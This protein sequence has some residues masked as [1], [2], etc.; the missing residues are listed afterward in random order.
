MFIPA[1]SNSYTKLRASF[2]QFPETYYNKSLNILEWYIIWKHFSA[3]LTTIN[4]MFQ[5]R[6]KQA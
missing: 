2:Q 3:D 6:E 5:F 4:E 1:R